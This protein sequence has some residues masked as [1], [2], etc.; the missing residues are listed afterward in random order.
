[1]I[2]KNMTAS[3]EQMVKI[4][5]PHCQAL[6]EIPSVVLRNSNWP[7]ACHHCSQHY[8]AP[9]VSGPEKLVR[10]KKI[11]CTNCKTK[12]VID[13]DKYEAVLSC[14]AELYCPDCHYPLPIAKG[15]KRK[16]TPAT[17]MEAL[18][19]HNNE[20]GTASKAASSGHPPILPGW[21]SAVFLIFAGFILTA[22]VMMAAQ[23]ELID[24]IWLDKFLEGLPDPAEVSAVFNSLLH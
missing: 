4:A 8:F 12:A 20:T 13:S 19:L 15:S 17:E 21:R 10:E 18:S 2:Q 9:V 5:C 3:S 23:E 22:L 6:G 1:M 14:T 16:K 7:I 11:T 24:R